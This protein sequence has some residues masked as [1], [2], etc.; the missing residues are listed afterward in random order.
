MQEQYDFSPLGLNFHFYSNYMNKFS[1]VLC[2]NMAV[3]QTTYKRKSNSKDTQ[4]SWRYCPGEYNHINDSFGGR[5]AMPM[6][7]AII[8]PR[9]SCPSEP[10]GAFARDPCVKAPTG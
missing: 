7:L 10:L 2:T 4:R 6:A 3:M 9:A 8:V 1:F 5:A